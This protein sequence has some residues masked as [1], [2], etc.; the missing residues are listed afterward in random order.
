M[1]LFTRAAGMIGSAV[2]LAVATVCLPLASAAPVTRVVS[3]MVPPAQEQAFNQGQSRYETCLRKHGEAHSMYAYEAAS[4]NL[5]QYFFLEPHRAWS[6]MGGHDPAG[7]ACHK[8]FEHAVL[9]H[10]GQIHSD[11]TVPDARDTY[12]PAGEASPA[13][14]LWVH[15]YRLKVGQTRKFTDALAKLAAAAARAHWDAHFYGMH[16]VGGGRGDDAN[17]VLVW[18]YTSWADIGKARN[19]SMKEMMVRAYGKRAAQVNRRK[20][21]AA[22]AAS[23][24]YVWRYDKAL[25]YLPGK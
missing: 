7:K 10:I 2:F 23:W 17:F 24:S 4:A 16:A 3:V 6:G 15:V 25:S 20:F 9:P 8:L 1:K 19:P 11:F 12:M 18:P 5:S 22:V 13:P 21:C 14:I